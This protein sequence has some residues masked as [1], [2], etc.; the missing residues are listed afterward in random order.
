MGARDFRRSS[1]SM[2]ALPSDEASLDYELAVA[3]YCYSQN[4][5]ALYRALIA[6]GI[7]RSDCLWHAAHPGQRR[8]V[9]A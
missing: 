1:P 3:D 6:I 7:C 5:A 8:M 4:R 9:K 2:I